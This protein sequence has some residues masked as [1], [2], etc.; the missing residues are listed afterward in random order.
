MPL[1]GW[2]E[3]GRKL[4]GMM[5]RGLPSSHHPPRAH[6]LFYLFNSYFMLFFFLHFLLEYRWE[7]LWRREGR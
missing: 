6:V 4:A 3:G 7:P 5:G 1:G 2:G